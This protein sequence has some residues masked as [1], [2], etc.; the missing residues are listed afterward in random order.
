MSSLRRQLAASFF[1]FDTR[2][3]GAFR[4]ALACSLFMDLLPRFGQLDDYELLGHFVHC[5]P[6]HST[7]PLFF[8]ASQ[9]SES[10]LLVLAAALVFGALLLGWF[11]KLAQVLSL[12]ALVSLDGHFGY[13]GNRLVGLLCLWGLFLPLGERFSI[14]AVRASLRRRQQ[15]SPAALNDRAPIR[16]PA[17][18]AYSLA[19]TAL[20]LQF[21]AIFLSHRTDGAVAPAA[22]LLAALL[23]NP[24]ARRYT[25]LLVIAPILAAYL[26]EVLSSA[27]YTGGRLSMIPLCALLLEPSH[28]E[29]L[30]RQLTRSYRRRVVF[31]DDD[32][33]FCMMCARLLARLDVLERLEFASNGDQERLPSGISLEMA[34]ESITTLDLDTGRVHRGSAAFAALLRS[35]P[36]GFSLAIPLTLPGLRVPAEAAY[37]LVARN[38]L[39]ISLWLGYAACGLP[40]TEAEASAAEPTPSEGALWFARV[41][42]YAREA[43]V[44]VLLIAAAYDLLTR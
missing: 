42:A 21:A 13:E 39:D 11:T 10:L 6:F 8:G 23:F 30:R 19:C 40:M 27:V 25:N 31:V 44:L 37:M 5:P 3:L 33:G 20:L 41:A 15:Q 18:R 32:C 38:R 28:W 12:L 29:F 43:C 22:V 14:D 36:F 7:F 9:R 2:S 1:S 26:A 34:N 4:I 35:L 24:F 17:R 16:T